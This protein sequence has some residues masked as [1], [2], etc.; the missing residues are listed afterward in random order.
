MRIQGHIAKAV[1]GT[2]MSAALAFA[3]ASSAAA[4]STAPV[5]IRVAVQDATSSAVPFFAANRQGYFKEA[6]LDVTYVSMGGGATAIAAALK[7]GEIDVAMGGAGQFMD[8]LAKG[9]VSGKIIAEN[10]DNGYAI[11]GANGI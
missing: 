4:Q 2:V 7:A 5:K 6:G 11:L 10:T 1:A 8:Y 9:M 3:C